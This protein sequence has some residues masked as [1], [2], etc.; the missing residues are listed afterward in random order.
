M[1]LKTSFEY[2]NDFCFYD[3]GKPSVSRYTV[4]SSSGEKWAYDNLW[5]AHIKLWELSRKD[6]KLLG[7]KNEK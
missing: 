5:E 6:R 2:K 7:A 3:I 4:Y 1:Q